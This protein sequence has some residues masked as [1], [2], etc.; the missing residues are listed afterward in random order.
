MKLALNWSQERLNFVNWYL[1][2]MY[3][4]EMD[5]TLLLFSTELGFSSMDMQNL[6]IIIFP[7]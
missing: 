4:V 1:C 6:K 7:C 3:N 2:G 5:P